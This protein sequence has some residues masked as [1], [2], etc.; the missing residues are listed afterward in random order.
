MPNPYSNRIDQ[1][2]PLV[3]GGRAVPGGCGRLSLIQDAPSA[4]GSREPF[5]AAGRLSPKAV[6]SLAQSPSQ[7][8][9]V[10]YAMCGWVLSN[11]P[12]RLGGASDG[13]LVL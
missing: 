1:D 5:Y 8:G 3:R 13:G 12:A 4:R 9:G 11:N 2:V 7:T 10:E 6:T